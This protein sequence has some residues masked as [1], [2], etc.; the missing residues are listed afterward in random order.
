LDEVQLTAEDP[1]EEMKS[2]LLSR[3]PAS[4]KRVAEHGCVEIMQSE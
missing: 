2:T 4:H 3:E 1:K